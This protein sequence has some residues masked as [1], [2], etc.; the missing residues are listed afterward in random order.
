[1]SILELCNIY[2]SASEREILSGLSLSIE[3]GEVHALLGTNGTGKSTLAHMIMG[4]HG[5]QPVTGE[6]I[7][8]G[9]LL[10]RQGLP[11]R[12]MPWLR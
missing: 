7:F 12:T 3:T 4:C 6:I 11:L 8:N 2:Y 10:S 1:M 9:T 5:Y